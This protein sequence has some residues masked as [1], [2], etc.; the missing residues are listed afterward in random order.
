MFKFL[1]KILFGKRSASVPVLLTNEPAGLSTCTHVGR[2]V[3]NTG[4]FYYA[5]IRALCAVF[6]VAERLRFCRV[7]LVIFSVLISP[8]LVNAG[9]A[10]PKPPPNWKPNPSGVGGLY[11]SD[12]SAFRDAANNNWY[13]DAAS[14]YLPGAGN[15]KYPVSMKEA[16]NAANFLAKRTFNPLALAPLALDLLK[17]WLA[18]GSDIYF[19][20][21]D[22]LWKKRDPDSNT[23]MTGFEYSLQGS[24]WTTNTT[25]LCNT[26]GTYLASITGAVFVSSRFQNDSC[27]TRVS[28][29]NTESETSIAVDKRSSPCPVGWVSIPAGCFP[30]AVRPAT[31]QEYE[32]ALSTLKIP[33]E[34][35]PLLPFGLPVEDPKTN[36]KPFPFGDPYPFFVPTGDPYPAPQP[37]PDPDPFPWREPGIDI[38]P[39]PKPAPDPDPWR[40]GVTPVVKPLP[41]PSPSPNPNPNP[42]PTP[43]PNPTPNPTP[44]PTPNPAPEKDPGLCALFPDIL[45]CEKLGDAPE[46]PELDNKDVN[47]TVTPA[48]GFGAENGTCP[49]DKNITIYHGL[50]IA[51]P[52]APLCDVAN[53]FRP[54]ILA[55]AWFSAAYIVVGAARKD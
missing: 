43:S 32:D 9:F 27:I 13:T 33:I 17:D 26:Y 46:Q 1:K 35:P 5:P 24:P 28:N 20:P 37:R 41:N 39:S 25:S 14:I 4:A 3:I 54:L 53:K 11:K 45:A 7:L 47:V 55:L 34:L 21:A 18:T 22:G 38:N 23:N 12:R 30:P 51:I 29:N 15:I 42:T 8:T 44:T 2:L 16:A 10:N 31:Q 36:P 52:W 49:S 19:D 6:S 48:S 50:Q 40:V